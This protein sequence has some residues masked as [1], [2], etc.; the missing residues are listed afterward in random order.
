[1]AITLHI[2]VSK[3]DVFDNVKKATGYTASKM[4]GDEDTYERIA[5][6]QGELEDLG[7]FW[8]EACNIATDLLKPFIGGG[9]ETD[10]YQVTLDMPS[11]FDGNLSASINSSLNNFFIL[12]ITSRWFK[13]ANKSE[14]SSTLEDAEAM[15]ADVKRK[16]YYKKKPTRVNT[17]N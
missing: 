7:V 17:F 8:L 9:V 11:S 12:Y 14:A 6:T 10:N 16:I 15:L 4:V 2:S 5:V 3:G 1:M 13:Y